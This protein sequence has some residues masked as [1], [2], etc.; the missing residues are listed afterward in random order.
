MR[1]L[2]GENPHD[3][4]KDA[5]FTETRWRC[6]CEAHRGAS[7]PPC[8]PTV[9]IGYWVWS[10][11][12][13]LEGA[14]LLLFCHFLFLA[15]FHLPLCFFF[16]SISYF[17]TF[18]QKVLNHFWKKS[19]KSSLFTQTEVIQ[20]PSP[21]ISLLFSFFSFQASIFLL[22]LLNFCLLALFFSSQ[23]F[24]FVLQL[25]NFCLALLY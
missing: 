12:E 24:I 1:I 23:I 3:K 19:T 11:G 15:A 9:I 25:F 13:M 2:S 8:S 14:F 22:E 5:N 10:W 21:V 16:Y 17:S 4:R 7:L 18:V 20:F 6:F